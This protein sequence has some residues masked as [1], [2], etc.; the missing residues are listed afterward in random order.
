VK[1]RTKTISTKV[2]EDEFTRLEQLATTSG[3]S[4]S[5]W[6]R[7]VLLEQLDP[8]QASPTEEI[9]LAEIL[10]LRNILVNLAH[11]QNQGERLSLEQ[12]HQLLA[13]ADK[14]KSRKAVE[15]LGAREKAETNGLSGIE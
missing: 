14:I 1:L 12:I 6:S 4:M 10:A 9:L 3:Q 13:K 5:E 15:R 8:I 7:Q 11:A 2:T